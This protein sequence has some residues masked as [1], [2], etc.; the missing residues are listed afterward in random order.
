[1]CTI[2]HW[3]LSKTLTLSVSLFKKKQQAGRYLFDPFAI[4]SQLSFYFNPLDNGK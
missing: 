1:M 3:L 4:A 2:I